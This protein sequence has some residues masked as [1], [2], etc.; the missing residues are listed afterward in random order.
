MWA[1]LVWA[2]VVDKIQT[3]RQ[4]PEAANDLQMKLLV[5]QAV[6]LPL[7]MALAC[8]LGSFSNL[9][10]EVFDGCARIFG[11]LMPIVCVWETRGGT[12]NACWQGVLGLI[13][14]TVL[15]VPMMS[16]ACTSLQAMLA[17]LTLA[18]M[19]ILV[20]D[21]QVV[22]QKVAWL[23]VGL[24]L[25]LQAAE[26]WKDSGACSMNPLKTLVAGLLGVAASLAVT[27]FPGLCACATADAERLIAVSRQ[28]AAEAA[29]I[30]CF[31]RSVG[32]HEGSFLTARAES[33]LQVSDE[34]RKKALALVEAV[35]WEVWWSSKLAAALNLRRDDTSYAEFSEWGAA[36]VGQ[37]LRRICTK[38]ALLQH[39]ISEMLL[40]CQVSRGSQHQE[41]GAIPCPTS[42]VASKHFAVT[43][44][45]GSSE[46]VTMVEVL[47]DRWRR[48]CATYDN[49]L[50]QPMSHLADCMLLLYGE[51]ARRLPGE[52]TVRAI[53]PRTPVSARQ[54]NAE[55]M[56]TCLRD[57]NTAVVSARKAAFYPEGAADRE[58]VASA[59]ALWGTAVSRL[60]IVFCAIELPPLLNSISGAPL[61]GPAAAVQSQPSGRLSSLKEKAASSAHEFRSLLDS[62]KQ[63]FC[64][65]HSVRQSAQLYSNNRWVFALRLTIAINVAVAL[66]FA[67]M[68]RGA[69]AAAAVIII[70]PRKLTQ[71]K[72]SWRGAGL[73][74]QG[75]VVG[76]LSAVLLIR[77]VFW[78]RYQQAFDAGAGESVE[79]GGDGEK[80]RGGEGGMSRVNKVLAYVLVLPFVFV[81]SFFKSTA[82]ITGAVRCAAREFALH[83]ARA[84]R[85]QPR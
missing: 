31:S 83:A 17:G 62:L 33:L 41:H 27:L 3:D 16:L 43:D 6:T 1:P 40:T 72:G 58:S 18:S 45:L 7:R 63:R 38:L 71:V 84:D 53:N 76:A 74:I 81:V 70:G 52:V 78:I 79:S 80:G 54:G 42:F 10:L 30:L 2:R 67:T 14:G 39:V 64:G 36:P 35:E 23:T 22:A 11:P 65:G 75:T 61:V 85:Q 9:E 57:L 47:W 77:F 55:L 34:A 12:L 26:T 44:R 56:A 59:I 60:V 25:C 49:I 4:V 50:A 69:A 68:G 32:D 48:A 21:S 73:R 82:S 24:Q 28:S 46:T 66:G 8:G 20:P 29:A 5:P 51:K 37:C 13:I 15:V 19:L